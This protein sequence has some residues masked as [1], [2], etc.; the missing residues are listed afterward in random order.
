MTSIVQDLINRQLA[1]SSSQS[2]EGAKRLF[3][4]EAHMQAMPACQRMLKDLGLAETAVLAAQ[5]GQV[6][7][8]PDLDAALD[9]AGI[10]SHRRI[11]FKMQLK[12]CGLLSSQ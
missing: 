2:A 6:F 12:K 1:A 11:E 3:A 4:L 9:Q 10:A 5:S 8:L 7:S